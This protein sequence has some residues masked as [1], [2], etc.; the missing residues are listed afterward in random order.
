MSFILYVKTH[1]TTGL[2]YLGQTSAKDPHKYPG[3]GIYWKKHLEKHGYNYTTEIIMECDSKQDIKKW[4]IYYSNLWMV[5]ES[6][7]WANLTREEGVGGNNSSYFSENY[8]TKNKEARD[9]WVAH[10]AGKTIEEIYGKEKSIKIKEKQSNALKG[11]KNNLSDQ[12][13]A[14]RSEVMI[15]HNQTRVWTADIIKKRSETFK[16]RGQNKGEKNGMKSVPSAKLVIAEKNSKTHLLKNIETGEELAV[17]NIS[18][19][20]RENGLNSST[21]LTKF[22]KN[23]AVNGWIRIGTLK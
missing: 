11:K 4:G 21:V 17:K 15:A 14:R 9:K 20:A 6:I 13:R 2:K 22:C 8:K 7:E 12:E 10:I 1:S 3:S 23:A 18:K 16:S 19:W 5:V